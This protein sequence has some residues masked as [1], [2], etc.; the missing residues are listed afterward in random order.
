MEVPTPIIYN[1][2]TLVVP[3]VLFIVC[4]L[5]VIASIAR[6]G[7]VYKNQNRVR[8]RCPEVSAATAFEI[9]G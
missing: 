3:A 6:M 4:L 1:Q 8:Q 7:A 2:I 5:V 9:R